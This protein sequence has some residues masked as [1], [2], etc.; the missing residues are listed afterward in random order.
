LSYETESSHDG[1]VQDQ[2]PESEVRPS[3]SP[4]FLKIITR[5]D[6]DEL[7]LRKL[8]IERERERE[9]ERA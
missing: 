3:K 4:Q 5:K 9:R 8:K 6:E 1:H 7:R 2:I